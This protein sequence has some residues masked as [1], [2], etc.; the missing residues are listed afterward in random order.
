ME[1]KKHIVDRIFIGF[2]KWIYKK[3]GVT[4]TII[5]SLTIIFG[6][7]SFIIYQISH[8]AYGFDLSDKNN[9]GDALGGL[10]SPFIGIM[11]VVL[12]FLAFYIQ[13]DFNKKQM[14]IIKNQNE[15]VFYDIFQKELSRL[16]SI[17]NEYYN[18]N[19]IVSEEF[20]SNSKNSIDFQLKRYLDNIQGFDIQEEKIKVL[21]FSKLSEIDANLIP[22]YYSLWDKLLRYIVSSDVQQRQYL[23][24]ILTN[25]IT[26]HF[27][28]LDNIEKTFFVFIICS[29]RNFHEIIKLLSNYHEILKETYLIKKN[30]NIEYQC[31]KSVLNGDKPNNQDVFIE[32]VLNIIDLNKGN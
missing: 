14:E 4:L 23:K 8:K 32:Q 6:L 30:K 10:T 3:L 13:F 25:T 18:E 15:L 7:I 20:N 11:G 9:I 26:N 28:S 21:F 29:N 12:T 5:F 22:K 16:I 31:V 17:K 19:L 2:G 24:S 27:N 1:E